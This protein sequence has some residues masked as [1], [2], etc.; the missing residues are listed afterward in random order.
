[1]CLC[2]TY[3]LTLLT[4]LASLILLLREDGLAIGVIAVC[5]CVTYILTLLPLLTLLTLLLQEDGL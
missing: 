4:L 1:M 5:L 2:V 3:V